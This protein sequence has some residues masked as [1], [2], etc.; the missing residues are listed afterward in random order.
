MF[1]VLLST[2]TYRMHLDTQVFLSLAFTLY[3]YSLGAVQVQYCSNF[4]AG[5][6]SYRITL[7]SVNAWLIRNTFIPDQKVIWYSVNAAIVI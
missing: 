1:T 7:S 3:Q 4:L 2:I 5:T 6:K